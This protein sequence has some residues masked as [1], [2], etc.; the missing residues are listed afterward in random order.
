[1][2]RAAPLL[3]ALSTAVCACADEVQVAV[4]ANFTAPM[5]RIAVEVAKD[6]GHQASPAFGATGKFYA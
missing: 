2:R 6:T 4:A 1:M 3:V 5:Q